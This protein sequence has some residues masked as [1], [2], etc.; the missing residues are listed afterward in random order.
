MAEMRGLYALPPGVD[1][2]DAF[3]RGLLERKAD[4]PPEA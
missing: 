2:A 1:F 3:V 4:Q